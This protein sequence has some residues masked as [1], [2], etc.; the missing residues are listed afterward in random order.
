ME[1]QLAERQAQRKM[2]AALKLQEEQGTSAAMASELKAKMEVRP[3]TNIDAVNV[4]KALG[5]CS[6]DD[7]WG[8]ERHSVT[9]LRSTRNTGFTC[10]WC[11]VGSLT[12]RPP[13]LCGK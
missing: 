10:L 6:K 13:F 12:L 9:V 1:G 4:T 7:Y 2:H 5:A 3:H 11:N 8:S